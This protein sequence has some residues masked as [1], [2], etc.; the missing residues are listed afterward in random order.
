[1]QDNLT[2]TSTL[3]FARLL[4]KN[5]DLVTRFMASP[6]VASEST[7]DKSQTFREAAGSMTALMRTSAFTEMMRGM[8]GNH[9]AFMNEL[10]RRGVSALGEV[11]EALVRHTG[12]AT[13]TIIKAAEGRT[14]PE[15]QTA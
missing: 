6:E 5:M 1:M 10:S 9:T 11:Q 8:L 13:D 12:R 2:S 4:Q 14:R 3:P 7:A 15:P